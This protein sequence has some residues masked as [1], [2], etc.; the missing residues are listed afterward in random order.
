[1]AVNSPTDEQL[2]ADHVRGDPLAFRQLVDR[3]HRELFSFVVRFT[4]SSA[5]ADDVVQ[6]AFVQVHL[7]A[8]TFDTERRLKPWLFT[9]A[10]NKARD[11]LR[12]RTRRKEVPLDAPVHSEDQAGA[13]GFGT[14][15][16]DDGP[17]PLDNLTETERSTIVR[18]VVNQMPPALREVLTLAYFHDFPYKDMADILD[19]PLG[20]VKSRLHAAVASFGKLFRDWQNQHRDADV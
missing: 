3:H 10:A 9:I 11:H 7:A 17:G 15:M 19:I 16:A 8:A 1:V 12:N 2:L 20:T 4:G 6:D 5:A 14:F 13:P 18:E